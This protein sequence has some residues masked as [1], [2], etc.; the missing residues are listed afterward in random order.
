MSAVTPI[1][2]CT[3]YAFVYKHIQTHTEVYIYIYIYWERERER[4]R[5]REKR[6]KFFKREIAVICL[7][8][9]LIRIFIKIVFHVSS[10]FLKLSLILSLSSFH[11]FSS[12][13]IFFIFILY[14]CFSTLFL[15]KTLLFLSISCKYFTFFYWEHTPIGL[16][17]VLWLAS[18]V[19]WVSSVISFLT[20]CPIL[21][22]L[23]IMMAIVKENGIAEPSPNSGHGCLRFTLR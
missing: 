7:Y 12:F 3:L 16:L 23:S 1:Q 2:I 17:V 9:L 22:A 8:K 15:F 10:H 18:K 6:G 4:E 11:L 19:C 13:Y 20:E 14:H 21:L 5:E